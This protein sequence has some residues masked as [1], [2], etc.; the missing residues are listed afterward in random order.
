MI[1]QLTQMVKKV[2]EDAVFRH[3]THHNAAAGLM[4]DESEEKKLENE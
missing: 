2:M 4:M 3:R 1:I